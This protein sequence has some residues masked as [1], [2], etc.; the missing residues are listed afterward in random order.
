MQKKVCT[1]CG[2]EKDIELFGIRVA[3]KD[4]HREVCKECR[5]IHTDKRDEERALRDGGLKRCAKC[6]SV[7]EV[8]YFPKRKNRNNNPSSYCYECEKKRSIDYYDENTEEC[9]KRSRRYMERTGYAKDYNKKNRSR[10]NEKAKKWIKENPEKIRKYVNKKYKE[11]LNYKIEKRLRVSFYR[12]VRRQYKTK[13]V[14]RLIG[15]QIDQFILY[16]ESLFT[17]GMTWDLFDN[18]KI[19]IDH[20]IPCKAFDLTN[21]IHQMACY[22]HKNLRPMWGS[23]NIKKGGKYSIN[24]FNTYMDWFL[25]NVIGKENDVAA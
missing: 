19:H 23:E 24:D 16:L 15:C 6:N 10:L 12:A 18:G 14:I 25:K 4:G 5:L 22:Y 7:K 13:S 1:K 2:L 20:I 3:S 11:N 9:N 17:E 21:P 8:I